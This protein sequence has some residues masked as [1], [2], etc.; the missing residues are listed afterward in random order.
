MGKVIKIVI[1][2]IV[3]IGIKKFKQSKLKYLNSL[4]KLFVTL[5]YESIQ[6]ALVQND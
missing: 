1:R 5:K 4:L 2:I 6:V 3:A